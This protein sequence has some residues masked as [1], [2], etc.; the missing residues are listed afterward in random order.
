MK[1]KIAFIVQRYGLEVNGGA[2]YH[3]RVIVEK[4]KDIYDIEV[5]TS[6]AKDYLTWA[7][8]YPEGATEIN[9]VKVQRFSSGME[10]D[11]KKFQSIGRKIKKRKPYQKVLRFVGLLKFYESLIPADIVNEDYEKWVIYQGPYLP[12]LL[13]HLENNQQQYDA[14]IFFTYL[15]YPTIEGIKIAPEKSILIPT[16]H[17]EPPIYFPFFKQFFNTPKA[18]L[19]NTLSEK[20]F[21]NKLFHNESIYSDIVGVGIEADEPKT[22]LR[23]QDILKSDCEYLIYIGRID[24]SKGCK[25]LCDYFLDYKRSTNKNIKLVLVGQSF[26]PIPVSDDILAMG[27]V[28]EDIKI[29]LLKNAKVLVIPSFYESLSLVTLESMSYGVPVIANEK[30]EV[31]KDHINNSHA[32]F[33]YDDFNSFKIAVD[34]I[35]SPEIDINQLS[36]NAKHY[37]AENYTWQV[38]IDK[39]DKAIDYISRR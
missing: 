2:E 5:L 16:A 33:L 22:K 10:R 14:L 6:C 20:R 18:I 23:V 1:K 26:M 9:G 3:C 32:G 24:A 13:N 31:L 27:F 30:C 8:E 25:V 12:T 34:K 15:Y 36:K 39:Y 38:T 11:W 28:D 35:F 7:D 37:V 19:Y 4:L 29:T 17:D 21:V